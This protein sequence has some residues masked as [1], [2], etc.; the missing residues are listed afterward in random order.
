MLRPPNPRRRFAM[1]PDT[2]LVLGLA[3]GA[4]V[5]IALVAFIVADI[6]RVR[7]DDAAVKDAWDRWQKDGVLR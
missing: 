2:L 1:S 5:V 3:C 4:A 6:R 7:R